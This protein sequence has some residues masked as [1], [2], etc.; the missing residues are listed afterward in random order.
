M[1][2]QTF[3]TLPPWMSD[4]IK[5]N[6]GKATK[7]NH[8]ESIEVTVSTLKGCEPCLMLGDTWINL[9]VCLVCGTV[10]CCDDSKNQHAGKHAQ[11]SNHPLIMSIEPGEQWFYCY[12][13]DT[14]FI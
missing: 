3:V 1:M 7:C 8:L 6:P 9:R 12:A 10:G 13:D 4:L 5:E 14:L 2:S 11:S